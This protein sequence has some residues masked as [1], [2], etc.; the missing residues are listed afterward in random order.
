MSVTRGHSA[1]QNLYGYLPR[2]KA[3]PLCGW[4]QII[5]PSDRGTR[6]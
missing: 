1:T 4:Y 2:R 3:S 5:L 6:V